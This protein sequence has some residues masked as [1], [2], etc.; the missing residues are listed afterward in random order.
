[1]LTSSKKTLFAPESL[2]Q[3]ESSGFLLQGSSLLAHD[4]GGNTIQIPL[5]LAG[6]LAASL[7]V[8][9]DQLDLF[10]RLHGLAGGTAIS[11]AEM[12][13]ADTS[14]L[15]TAID[16]AESTNTRRA[17]VVQTTQDRGTAYVEPV[18][19]GGGQLLEL[20]GLDQINVIGYL[21]LTG[22]TK[23]RRFVVKYRI[24]PLKSR[25]ATHFFKK[26]ATPWTTLS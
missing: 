7:G 9:L 12:R 26:R 10:Q 1:M 14:A 17:L 2:R 13:W 5:A 18:L 20:G 6:Q 22:P 3:H 24:Y 21:Q 11:L 4:L 8:L 23:N 16:T 15:A 19:V 25:K